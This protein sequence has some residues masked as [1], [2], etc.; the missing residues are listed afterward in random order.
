MELCYLGGPKTSEYSFNVNNG[1]MMVMKPGCQQALEHRIWPGSKSNS[2]SPT[3][4]D[5][6]TTPN[7]RFS[8][9][10]RKLSEP[11]EDNEI[12]F[13]SKPSEPKPV[14][15]RPKTMTKISIIAGDSLVTDLDPVKL[16]R[17]GKKIVKNLSKGG[18]LIRDV[19]NQIDEFY[20][21]IDDDIIVEKVFV[22]V[23]TNDIR[24]CRKSGIGH[25][26]RHLFGL[27]NKIKLF[28]PGAK[29]W[30]QSL[31]PLPIQNEWTIT[32]IESYNSMLYDICTK[33]R[34]FYLN[35]FYMFLSYTRGICLRD[36][37]FFSKDNIHPKKSG[38]IM[39]ARKYLS[40]IYR[41]NFNPLAY[42]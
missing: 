28:F 4:E 3:P 39:I 18:A 12:S 32:N 30:F 40:C 15:P 20:T 17:N 8:I 42:Q 22:C 31:I 9:S 38:V 14:P 16:G 19:C 33:S 29:I 7:W 35:C 11:V 41:N 27:I 34:I 10:F 26:R 23:G 36:E 2:Q 6:S 21:S 1:D 13:D 25:L 37:Q 24:Y 5:Q